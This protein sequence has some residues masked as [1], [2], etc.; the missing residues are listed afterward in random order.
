M[1]G[2]LIQYIHL[3]FGFPRLIDK[4]YSPL[5]ANSLTKG[6]FWI[7]VVVAMTAE[8]TFRSLWK[9]EKKNL[10]GSVP[11]NFPRSISCFF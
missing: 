5:E 3:S 8:R 9:E 1:D 11:V 4:G 2:L 7:S 10:G 6:V